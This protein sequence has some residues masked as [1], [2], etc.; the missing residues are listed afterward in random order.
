MGMRFRTWASRFLFAAYLLVF[1]VFWFEGSLAYL[2]FEN[3]PARLLGLAYLPILL[4]PSIG[5]GTVD[6]IV[7]HSA[8]WWWLFALQ[9]TLGAAAMFMYPN[10][11]PRWRIPVRPRKVVAMGGAGMA[12]APRI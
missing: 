5:S 1:G 2:R 3:G 7:V 4:L 6:G 9:M 11:R 10:E 12:R 8:V